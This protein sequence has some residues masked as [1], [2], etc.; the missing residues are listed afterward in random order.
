MNKPLILVDALPRILD[1]ICDPATWRRLE[2]LV[3]LVLFKDR[4]M[5]DE[6]I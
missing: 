4:R 1:L 3:Q 5:P 6:V 2:S